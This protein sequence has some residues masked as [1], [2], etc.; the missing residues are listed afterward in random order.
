[1]PLL[2]VGA[3]RLIKGTLEAFNQGSLNKNLLLDND[4][5]TEMDAVEELAILSIEVGTLFIAELTLILYT[6]CCGAFWYL[7][8]TSGSGVDR[9]SIVRSLLKH[10][11]LFFSIH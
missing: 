9:Q 5:Q 6:A 2:Q 10:I 8:I 4:K 7:R 11:V 1:M 3:E